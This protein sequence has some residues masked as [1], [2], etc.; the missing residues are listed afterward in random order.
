[1]CISKQLYLDLY[2]IGMPDETKSG[3]D[4]DL[5]SGEYMTSF[6]L[7]QH[8]SLTYDVQRHTI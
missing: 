4:F 6:F 3:T 2:C 1:M 8:R 5:L 7:L